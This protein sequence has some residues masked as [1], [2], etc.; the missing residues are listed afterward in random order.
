MKPFW[1]KEDHAW[2]HELA[3]LFTDKFCAERPECPADEVNKHF[4]DRFHTLRKLLNAAFN[5]PGGLP[6]YIDAER[7]RNRRQGRKKS[8]RDERLETAV[9]Q[10]SSTRLPVWSTICEVVTL[11]GIEGMSSDESDKDT[12]D[13]FVVSK[14][15]RSHDISKLLQYTD[16]QRERHNAFGNQRAGNCPRKRHRL[17]GAKESQKAALFRL[18]EN[19]YNN[20]W[21][22]NVQGRVRSD[23]KVLP[24]IDLPGMDSIPHVF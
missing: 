19:L 1:D 9:A 6:A 12:G 5:H 16:S 21:L 24:A 13:L 15:W 18:P 23:L 20:H 7:R 10:K 2:N 3:S 22:L 14:P 4:L 11:L 17:L 8:R